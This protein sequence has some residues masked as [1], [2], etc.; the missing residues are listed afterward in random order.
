MGGA[1]FFTVYCMAGLDGG[2]QQ[3]CHESVEGAYPVFNY[4]FS[5]IGCSDV[6][7]H[8]I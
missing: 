6:I 1:I 8:S 5:Q 3:P 7:Y 4:C 2:G